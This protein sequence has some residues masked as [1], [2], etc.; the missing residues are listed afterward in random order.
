MS[1][2]RRDFLKKGLLGSAGLLLSGVVGLDAKDKTPVATK[3]TGGKKTRIRMGFIGCG[4]RGIT[5]I[6]ECLR[7]EDVD[8][9]AIADP[10]TQWAIPMSM[11]EMEGVKPGSS[12]KVKFYSNGGKDYLNMLAKEKLDAVI[13]ATP[14]EL[15]AEQGIAAMKAGVAVGMEVC[16]ALNVQECWD[17]VNAYEQTGTPF[18]AMENVAY[19]RTIMAV[20]NMVRKGLFGEIIHL[21]GGYQHDL[22]H[23]KFNNGKG[24]YDKGAEFGEKG[25]S[26]AKWR[27]AHSVNRNGD[28][29]PTHGLGPVANMIDVNRGNRLVSLTSV[30]S[31]ARGLH[32]Y[33]VKVGGE[34]HPNAKVNF[35]L[36]DVVTTMITCANGE[37]IVLTHD[38]NLPRPYSLGFR[39]QGEKGIWSDDAKGGWDHTTDRIYFDGMNEKH[40]WEEGKKH[41]EA[42]DHPVWQ[43]Y[44]KAAETAGHGGMDFFMIHSFVES[45]KRNEPCVMDVYD[46]ATWYAI[47]PLSEASVAQGGTPQQIPDFTRG[48]WM[49]RKPIFGLNDEY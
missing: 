16:G 39:V 47:T 1:D 17:M 25:L 14:W 34:N 10:D 36:G 26:E 32:N 13:V 30:A 37:T 29:Y 7:R 20:L 23:V 24:P 49:S 35:K 42:Y 21:Q 18:F 27:T 38:T 19:K 4:A 11:K 15:H 44:G 40:Y 5:H 43:K 46:L 2:N 48:K 33:V 8:V 45:L 12:K 22:R 9:V 6:E 28:L 3:Y 41:R 31:K